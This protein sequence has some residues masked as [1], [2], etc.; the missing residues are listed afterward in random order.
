MRGNPSTWFLRSDGEANERLVKKIC[1]RLDHYVPLS[2][3]NAVTPECDGLGIVNI[4]S[5][6]FL[7]PVPTRSRIFGSL[8]QGRIEAGMRHAASTGQVFHL[9]W[10][11]H[12]FGSH[13]DDNM[14]VLRRIME[15]YRALSE[16]QGMISRTMGEI[17]AAARPGV[18]RQLES[19]AE[20][21][22]ASR[23]APGGGQDSAGQ[24]ERAVALG[25]VQPG[26]G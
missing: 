21:A 15:R 8:C 5:S 24:R 6:R 17:A 16:V 19:L 26:A 14:A 13:V 23:A 25:P 9:W 22:K 4:R 12:N 18:T 11:P 7:L 2:G 1:R 3:H 10:H 20:A